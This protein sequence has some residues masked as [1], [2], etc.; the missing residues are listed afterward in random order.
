ML[1]TSVFS[2]DCGI[3]V[4]MHKCRNLSGNAVVLG[5]NGVVNGVVERSG[6]GLRHQISE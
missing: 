2:R 6:I 3:L 1:E 4:E 5:G